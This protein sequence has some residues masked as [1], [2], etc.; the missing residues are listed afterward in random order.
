LIFLVYTVDSLIYL[1]GISFLF[2]GI[3][4]YN[5]MEITIEDKKLR[6]TLESEKKLKGKYGKLASRIMQRLDELRS[7]ETLEALQQEMPHIHCHEL[8]GDKKG[9]LAVNI[10]GNYRL[11]FKPHEPQPLKPD[12]GLDWKQIK[13]II[14]IDIVDYH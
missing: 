8:K 12:G 10:S 14:I 11:L 4:W 5:L 13:A 7:F 6:N 3:D 1:F 9:M 2:H